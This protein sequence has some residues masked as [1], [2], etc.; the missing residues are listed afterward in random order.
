MAWCGFRPYPWQLNSLHK[1][2][3]LRCD[4]VLITRY[5]LQFC[6]S[7]DCYR[8]NS[9]LFLIENTAFQSTAPENHRG[10]ACPLPRPSY[11]NLELV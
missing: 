7:L 5:S 6:L 1:I 11:S 10:Y 3:H 9:V 4:Y 2:K 8:N